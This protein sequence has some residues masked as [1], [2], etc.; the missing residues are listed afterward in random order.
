M[1]PVAG[2][3]GRVGLKGTDGVVKEAIAKGAD[4][5]APQ[6]A[7]EFLRE[8][9]ERLSGNVDLFC[10]PANMGGEEA[11]DAGYSP[12][13]LTMTIAKETSAKDTMTAVRLLIDEKS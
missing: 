4:P 2:M 1:N 3:G 10:P 6:R 11:K 9:K 8:L 13:V 5:V 12:E 7:T